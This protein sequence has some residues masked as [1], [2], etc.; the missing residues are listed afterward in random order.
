MN[1]T[2]VDQKMNSLGLAFDDL[3]YN[4][5]SRNFSDCSYKDQIRTPSDEY[6]R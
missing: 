3:T 2:C 6:F 1:T 4:L 5:T